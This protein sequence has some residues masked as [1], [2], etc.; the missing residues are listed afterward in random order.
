[1][2][3]V[4]PYAQLRGANVVGTLSAMSLCEGGKPKRFV[5]VSSTSVLDTEHYVRLSDNIL[6]NGGEGVPESDDLMGSRTK[7]PTGYGQSKWV[8]EQLVMEAGKRGLQG[9][10]IRPGYIVGDSVTGGKFACP[11]ISH[12]S[13]KYGR[14]SH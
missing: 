6:A 4:Y 1:M 14:F 8:S 2:H 13:V 12:G 9:I 11:E 7:L 10:I 5:F 3:W